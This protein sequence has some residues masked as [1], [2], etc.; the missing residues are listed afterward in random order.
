MA[1]ATSEVDSSVEMGDKAETESDFTP[2]KT[3]KRRKDKEMETEDD[4]VTLMETAAKRPTF[5]PVDATTALVSSHTESP[6]ITLSGYSVDK[7]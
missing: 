1:S 6:Y 3:R 4:D 7:Y 2:V 5:P